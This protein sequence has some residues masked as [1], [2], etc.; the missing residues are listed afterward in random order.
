MALISCPE[1]GKE[2]SDTNSKCPF[3]GY[4]LK[5]E[6]KRRTL[7][8]VIIALVAVLAAAVAVYTLVIRPNQLLQ[9]AENLIARGKYSEADVI[10]TEVPDSKKKTA[11][12]TQIVLYEAEA[13]LDAGD[14]V[15]AEKKIA[16]LPPDAID[17]A[18][19]YEINT[20]KAAAILGQGRYIE[21]DALYA[22]LEQTEEVKLSREKLFFE[23]RVLYCA[24]MLQDTLLF[25][26]TLVL[27]EVLLRYESN[28][29]K[30]QSTDTQEVYVYGE[31]AVLLHYRAQSRGGTMVDGFVRFTWGNSGYK[32]GM[33]VDTLEVD[34]E[35]PWNYDY[36]DAAERTEYHTKQIEIC[37]INLA[38]LS[39]GWFE[40]YD[41]KRMNDVIKG[42]FADEVQ[43]IQY[44][45]IVPQ[46][47]PRIKTVTPKPTSTPKPTA[48][49]KP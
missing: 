29:D 17:A 24:A 35:L 37:E 18:L 39:G 28:L 48:A 15:L 46:P 4:I 41:M 23:T 16:M 13:A 6:T 14:F 10:L 1:C 31:P 38:L 2:I 9:Q 5:K 8:L 20:Q 27:E 12:V 21:A 40:T 44:N 45:E 19:L 26:E 3:C 36:M 25:P 43:P 42:G 7:W 30:N 33:I 22:E 11:L 34:D 32:M 47:T 49:P